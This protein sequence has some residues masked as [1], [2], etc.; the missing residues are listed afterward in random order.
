MLFTVSDTMF[1]ITLMHWD[2]AHFRICWYHWEY[3]LKCSSYFDARLLLLLLNGNWRR[4]LIKS[5]SQMLRDGAATENY[6]YSLLY[7]VMSMK[8]KCLQ[9]FLKAEQWHWHISH[10]WWQAVPGSSWTMLCIVWTMLCVFTCL[11]VC[12]SV[13]IRYCIKTAELI[14]DI[15]LLSVILVFCGQ[16]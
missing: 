5:T 14:I 4:K 7:S 13:I 2:A 6:R 11:C 15:L 16:N 10:V 8:Q 1:H 9:H 12:L 3:H